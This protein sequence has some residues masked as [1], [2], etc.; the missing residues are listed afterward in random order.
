M[1]VGRGRR[2][3]GVRRV[4]ACR[5][6]RP[7]VRIAAGRPRHQAAGSILSDGHVF[8]T[9]VGACASAPAGHAVHMVVAFHHVAASVGKV[10]DTGEV[11]ADAGRWVI[12]EVPAPAQVEVVGICGRATG[13]Q[14]WRSCWCGCRVVPVLSRRALWRRGRRGRGNGRR[15]RGMRDGHAGHGGRNRHG[16]SGLVLGC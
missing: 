15:G 14:H 13:G 9:V 1:R 16:R 6:G 11:A 8:A 7:R 12:D 3:G 4:A 2:G 5:Q 10:L